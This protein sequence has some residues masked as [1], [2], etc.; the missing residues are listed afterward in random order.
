MSVPALAPIPAC[1]TEEKVE[2]ER[3]Q[4]VFA[5]HHSDI[6]ASGSHFPDSEAHGSSRS[7]ALS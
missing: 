7:L 5:P 2:A 1:I 4:D 3:G 6:W